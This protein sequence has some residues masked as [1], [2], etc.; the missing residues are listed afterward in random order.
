M[1]RILS[2]LLASAVVL[3]ACAAPS[4]PAPT[5]PPAAETRPTD[6]PTPTQAAASGIVVTHAGGELTLPA[7]AQRII[8]LGEEEADFLIA[9]GLQ[10]IGFA[11]DRVK[12][13]TQGKVYEA[14]HFFNKDQLGS[15]VYLGV[16]S[17]PAI[18]EIVKLKPDLIISGV[19]NKDANVRLAAIA[20]TFVLDTGAPGYWRETLVEIGRAVGRE[21]Q[22]REYIEAFAATESALRE[23]VAPIAKASPNVLFIYSYA[24]DGTM[25]LGKKWVGSRAL[26]TLGFNVIEPAN[27]DLT[28]GV[29]PVSPEIVSTEKADIIMVIRLLTPDGEKPR[30]PIDALLESLKGTRVI[31]Q[32]TDS[33]R[34]S[35]APYTDKFSLEQI[36]E[37]VGGQPAPAASAATPAFPVTIKHKFGETTITAEPKRVLALGYSDQDPILALGVIPIAVRYWWGDEKDA[38]FPWAKDKLSE[39]NGATPEVLNIPYRQMNF[40]KI[41]L[42]KPDVIIATYSG[43]DAKEYENLSKIAPTV[44]QSGDYPDFGQPWQET[45]LTIGKALGREELAKKLVAEVEAK[46]AAFREKY[47]QYQGKSVVIGA[48]GEKNQFNFMA[49][50]DP[51]SRVFQALGF[52]VPAALDEIAGG[53]FYGTLSA[54]RVDLIDLDLIAYHQLQWVAGGRAAIEADPILS[55]LEAMKQGR[56]VYLEGTLDDAFQF[57]SVLSLPEVLEQLEPKLTAALD[58]DPKT[59]VK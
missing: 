55:K 9:L 31:Y 23:R 25:L 21:S 29:A 10:P 8:A 18:E 32:L 20:P 14:K 39:L 36:A 58:G 22:A 37:L 46:F 7:P 47:P 15:P 2:I 52:K 30:Y 56:A 53:S 5:S 38:I 35:T 26:E 24:A 57:A 42:L 4:A 48:P 16:S 59:V 45:T 27:L 11:S 41:A 40:E 50:A 12:N 34:P 13:G 33:T 54:E 1:I 6:A 49:S 43:I 19:W 51:R 28:T 3:A 17:T 44:A